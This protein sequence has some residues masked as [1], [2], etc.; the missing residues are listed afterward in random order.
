MRPLLFRVP[1]RRG[2][3]SVETRHRR[4]SPAESP[5]T[6]HDS[7]LTRRPPQ[8]CGICVRTNAH[9]PYHRAPGGAPPG[10]EGMDGKEEV[11]VVEAQPGSVSAVASLESLDV[12]DKLPDDV[13]TPFAMDV[14]E[15]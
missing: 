14:M 7:P 8:H 12:L 13:V 2:P 11:F 3:A 4:D 9:W 6:R 1:P 5:V 10:A 15:R